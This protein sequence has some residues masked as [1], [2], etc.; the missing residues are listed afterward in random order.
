MTLIE[1]D[2]TGIAIVNVKNDLSNEITNVNNDLSVEISNVKTKLSSEIVSVKCDTDAIKLDVSTFK[3]DLSRVKAD[4]AKI[5]NK[6][7]SMEKENNKEYS[8]VK[9]EI[10]I[11]HQKTDIN[12]ERIAR[13]GENF[14]GLRSEVDEK[15]STMSSNFNNQAGFI[16]NE[17]SNNNF[18]GIANQARYQ[19]AIALSNN[20]GI[21]FSGVLI[22]WIPFITQFKNNFENIINDNCALFSILLRHLKGEALESVHAC[23]F[24]G[25][26]KDQYTQ[27]L[28][29]LNSRYGQNWL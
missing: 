20:P 2:K 7:E 14:I 26:S 3:K 5:E 1:L 10:G 29:I 9:D 15:I 25:E 12:E 16:Y 23:V 4:M 8:Q 13:M 21:Y 28:K 22:E 19:A 24:N 6:V 18:T 27:A 11:I 17:Q